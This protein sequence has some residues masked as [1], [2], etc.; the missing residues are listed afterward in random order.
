MPMVAGN[1]QEL[2]ALFDAVCDLPPSQWKAA[3]ERISDDPALIAETLALLEAQT[4]S[5][6]RALQPLGELMSS[7]DSSELQAGDPLGPWRL[8]ERLASGG[9]GTVFIAERADQLFRQRVAIKLLHVTVAGEAARQRLAA[10]RQILA[11]LQHPNIARLYDGGTTPA[12]HPYLVM[13]FIEGLPLDRHCA[14][15]GLDLRERLQL[16]L[17]V[18]RAVQAAHQQLVVHC[19]LKPSNILVRDNVAPVLLDFGIARV[20]RE[21]D[22]T[23]RTEFC[24]PAYASPEQL[25]GGWVSVTSDVF[26]LGVL[27]TELL[28]QRKLERDTGD[29]TT[30]VPAPSAWATP[31]CRWRA[32][33]RGDLDAVAAKACELDPTLRYATVQDLIADLNAWFEQRPVAAR[34]G[35][36]GYRAH[37]YLR[38]HALGV[39]MVAMAGCALVAGLGVAIWEGQKAREQRDAAIAEAAKSRAVLDFMKDLFELADPNQARGKEVTAEEVLNSGLLRIRGQFAQQP[40]ARAELL[41]AMANAQRGLGNYQEA[42]PLAEEAA[43]LA[44][45]AQ[46]RGLQQIQDLNRARILHQLGRYRE[47]LD[48]LAPLSQVL[49]GPGRETQLLRADVEH[50][51]GLA[52]QA[53]NQ[54]DEA[55]AAYT[56]AYRTRLRLLGAHDRRV[57]AVEMSLISL[58]VLRD[59][60]PEAERHARG[61]L[62]SIRGSTSKTD[63]HL[64][65]ALGALAMVLSNTGPLAEAEALRREEL[66][67]RRATLGATHP[68]TVTALNNLAAV[69]YS[70]R[71]FEQAAQ[72]F[73]EVLTLR[74]AQ[75]GNAHPAVATV[76]NNL[77]MC[78]LESGHAE[79]GR[80][81]AQEALRI[82]MAKFGSSHHTTATSLHT[83]GAIEL[84]LGEPQAEQHL[85]QSVASWEAAMGPDST[86]A[87]NALR[88]MTSAQLLFGHVE[89]DCASAERAYALLAKK[90]ADRVAYTGA[91]RAACWVAVGRPGA[92]PTF[93]Q[94]L[95][96]LRGLIEAGDR[97]LPRIEAVAAAVRREGRASRGAGSV[98]PAV[99][100]P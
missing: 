93:D 71:H 34:Q 61:L 29:S 70:G 25:D 30:P 84:D 79:Q 87:A 22:A 8:V 24:T 52:L 15:H 10:E 86:L 4:A 83:L 43:Q 57:H 74:R 38:R 69:L 37:C 39:A 77:A 85:R 9:M 94:E 58:Y 32:R 67:I 65:D 7:L 75:Y 55:N 19:D 95:A 48:L 17:R 59:E 16:F 72:M 20:L 45:Q 6:N 21:A 2:R 35:G 63:P 23:D 89:T 53:D 68:R 41:G 1:L 62:A 31:D 80:A 88:D 56:W 14:E 11:E 44:R 78:E 40:E 33:L 98:V 5:F 26:S 82:R 28:A 49:T 81:L 36:W 47:A 42:L 100:Q 92:A 27:L 18:C 54:L 12:G 76:A 50:A 13:E 96:K 60:M 3:L 46:D 66:A 64:A 91:I 97:R 73:R 51:R 99:P 90:E